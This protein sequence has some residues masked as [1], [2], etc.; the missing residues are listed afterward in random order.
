MNPYYIMPIAAGL[1][2][3]PF[4]TGCGARETLRLIIE[5]IFILGG[6]AAFIHLAA[7]LTNSIP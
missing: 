4:A 1:A 6:A 2:L 7:I 3:L 5:A